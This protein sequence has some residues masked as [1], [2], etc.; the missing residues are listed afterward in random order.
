ME[1]KVFAVREQ[2]PHWVFELSTTEVCSCCDARKITSGLYVHIRGKVGIP[3]CKDC[4][5][6]ADGFD[7]WFAKCESMRTDIP[8][9]FD[10]FFEMYFKGY[11]PEQAIDDLR[12]VV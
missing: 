1:Q 4:Y 5:N 3:C 11:K 10:W 9:Q 2:D 8:K 7:E 6:T 12:L